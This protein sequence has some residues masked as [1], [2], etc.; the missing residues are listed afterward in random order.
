L[1]VVVFGKLESLRVLPLGVQKYQTVGEVFDAFFGVGLLFFPRFAAQNVEPGFAPLAADVALDQVDLLNGQKDGFFVGV[2]HAD[3]VALVATGTDA[4]DALKLADTVVHVHHE[5]VGGQIDETLDGLAVGLFEAGGSP[6][7]AAENFVFADDHDLVAGQAEPG[8][9]AVRHHRDRPA[10]FGQILEQ[11]LNALSLTLA[12]GKH[13]HLVLVGQ[14]C[15]HFF[16]EERH[17]AEKRARRVAFEFVQHDGRI[18]IVL[19]RLELNTPSFDG[20]EGRQTEKHRL[21]R[22]KSQP[23]LHRLVKQMLA[24]SLN[25]AALLFL[26]VPV[27]EQENPV[28]TGVFP[29]PGEPVEGQRIEQFNAA[30]IA[31]R[32]QLVKQGQRAVAQIALEHVLFQGAA[33]RVGPH[34]LARGVHGQFLERRGGG[35]RQRVKALDVFNLVEV[36]HHPHGIVV[37]LKV[38]IEHF[39]AQG[40][41]AGNRHSGHPRIPQPYQLLG[42]F[43]DV[44][45]VADRPR[46]QVGHKLGHRGHRKQQCPQR[47]HH[48]LGLLSRQLT[49]HPR[50]V[51]KNAGLGAD[52]L[53]QQ[54]APPGEHLGHDSQ[55]I[56]VG[57]EGLGLVVGGGDHKHRSRGVLDERLHRQGLKKP[58]GSFDP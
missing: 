51:A 10:S 48:H 38:Q 58:L 27:E 16:F 3:V 56:E 35:L 43:G 42:R 8:R 40:K 30:E 18:R 55:R 12:L 31:R 50:A 4:L 21:G 41:L 37:T 9:D 29:Q 45:G 24:L 6:F 33:Q 47:N 49:E 23:Q 15:L 36:E 13:K 20:L 32:G 19:E 54:R 28:L 11:K 44:D 52:A 26:V 2:G 46:G 57:R 1:P 39:A 5:I 7:A 53:V 22:W 14:Q 34:Q 17:V 25:N